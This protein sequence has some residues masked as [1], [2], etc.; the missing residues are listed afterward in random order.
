MDY[1]SHGQDA[2][3]PRGHDLPTPAHAAPQQSQSLESGQKQTGKIIVFDTITCWGIIQPFDGSNLIPG[4]IHHEVNQNVHLHHALSL[5]VSKEHD[6]HT[7][8]F[9]THYD[10]ALENDDTYK[11]IVC[12]DSINNLAVVSND[13]GRLM[14][15]HHTT[16]SNHK[17]PQDLTLPLG[18][19]IVCNVFR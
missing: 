1:F 16:H 18:C 15:I 14:V 3:Q 9:D 6:S 8:A 7:Y 13:K 19:Q 12:W 17:V 11:K 2:P 4:L 10:I 5:H